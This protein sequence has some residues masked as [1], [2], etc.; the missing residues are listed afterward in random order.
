ME[1]F[2]EDPSGTYDPWLVEGTSDVKTL[3]EEPKGA[4][5]LLNRNENR[6][7]NVATSA[8]ATQLLIC[9]PLI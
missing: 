9:T 5:H 6:R 2:V 7:L 4:C 1:M 8:E 3:A